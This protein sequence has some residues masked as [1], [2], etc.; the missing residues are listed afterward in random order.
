MPSAGDGKDRSLQSWEQTVRRHLGKLHLCPETEG[1]VI[2]ELASHFEQLYEEAL[3]SGASESDAL[4]G[5][6]HSVRHWARFRRDI[7]NA[8]E[9]LMT[10]VPWKRHVL[11]PGM[12]ALALSG[13]SESIVYAT[14]FHSGGNTR[15][16]HV[17]WSGNHSAAVFY[18]P[19]LAALLFVGAVSAWFA[20]RNGASASRRLL[21]ATFP[22]LLNLAIFLTLLVMVTVLRADGQVRLVDKLVSFGVY[23]IPWVLT[24]AACGMIGALPFV[25]GREKRPSDQPR[26]IRAPA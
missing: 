18:L 12:L 14:R 5:A 10:T 21:V 19:W 8:K 22:A 11:W 9:T 3:E 4:A 23:M 17:A 7:R 13:L 6:V 15:I 2:R 16:W 26:V 20:R 24:P 25:L 1:D